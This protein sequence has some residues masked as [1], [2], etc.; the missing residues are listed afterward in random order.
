MTRSQSTPVVKVVHKNGQ[1]LVFAM[2]DRHNEAL[3]EE[4][5]S[6]IFSR[7]NLSNDLC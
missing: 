1:T 4:M 6:D 2:F 3:A 5:E 7:I